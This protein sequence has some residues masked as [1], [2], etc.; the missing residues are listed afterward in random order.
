MPW[1]L[2]LLKNPQISIKHLYAQ[3]CISTQL[4]LRLVSSP[5]DD[6]CINCLD[7]CHDNIYMIY[8]S[9]LRWLLLRPGD[10]VGRSSFLWVLPPIKVAILHEFLRTHKVL[11][12]SLNI[13]KVL[14]SW[15][16]F[17]EAI[18][19]NDKCLLSPS[20]PYCFIDHSYDDGDDQTDQ[21]DW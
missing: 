9:K 10:I 2:K 3:I 7:L 11:Q 19:L 14:E 5:L 17:S 8:I 1:T 6:L 20:S 4:R 16:L 15:S 12:G 18:A 21:I 13:C